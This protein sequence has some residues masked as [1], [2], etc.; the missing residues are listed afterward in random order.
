[1]SFNLLQ[2]N[3][4][5]TL[6]EVVVLIGV[7]TLLSLAI[8]GSVTSLYQQ[9]SYALAQSNEIENARRG[10]TQWN[11][12][13]KEMRTAEDG[14]FPIVLIEEHHFGYFSDTDQDEDIE[15][16]EYILEDTTLTKYSYEPTGSPPVYDFS[17]PTSEEVLSL[18]VQN[19]NQGT[20][21]FKYYDNAG[22]QLNST[23]P[24]IDVRYITAQII[25]NIDPLRSPGEFMLRSSI[26]PRN[27]KDNL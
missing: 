1:M 12:D 15:Y 24:I 10:M 23:S 3:S 11:R 20:S 4:G 6:V 2:K 22:N 21:T 19:I 17:D 13:A 9:N 8:A 14:T 25:V 26:A 16:V 27:L 5:M 7:Y 18:Y